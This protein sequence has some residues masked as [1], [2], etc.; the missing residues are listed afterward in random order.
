MQRIQE[1]QVVKAGDGEMRQGKH[2]SVDFSVIIYV[3]YR[4][5]VDTDMRI[6]DPDRVG[7]HRDIRYRPAIYGSGEPHNVRHHCAADG[8][9]Q[10]SSPHPK[11]LGGSNDPRDLS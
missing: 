9:E 1:A 4:D 2:S 7:W 5:L 11:L 6:Y 10:I 8:D 3:I